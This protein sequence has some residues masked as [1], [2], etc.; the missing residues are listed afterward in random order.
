MDD[1]TLIQEL[2]SYLA[3]CTASRTCRPYGAQPAEAL[4]DL[5]IRLQ[6]RSQRP[7]QNPRAWVRANAAGLLR[8]FLRTECRQ[9]AQTPG[10]RS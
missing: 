5:Y 9:L 3:S 7:I 1:E 10:D 6:R 2:T 4:G 8:N